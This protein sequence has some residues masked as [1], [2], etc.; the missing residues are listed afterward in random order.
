MVRPLNQEWKLFGHKYRVAGS[1]CPK[2]DCKACQAHVS[3]AINRL[4]SHLRVCPARFASTASTGSA[5]SNG[6]DRSKKTGSNKTPRPVDSDIVPNRVI[7]ATI[8]SSPRT[9]QQQRRSPSTDRSAASGTHAESE[10]IHSIGAETVPTE[11]EVATWPYYKRRRLE[12][13]ES[14]LQLE[15]KRDQRA[16][17]RDRLE[18]AILE[19]QARKEKVLAEKEGYESKVL[20]ALSRKKLLSE[21]VDRDEIDR[22]LP[23]L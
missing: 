1:K 2:V 9:T 7:Q 13:E 3:A 16:E 5:G 19:T 6:D 10:F 15:I 20:L 21:G 4:Q 14:R 11:E 8:P 22:I 17:R 23:V 12:I 18:V